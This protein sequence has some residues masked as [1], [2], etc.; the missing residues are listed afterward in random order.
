MDNL[1]QH[2][3]RNEVNESKVLDFCR[4][5]VFLL[6][7]LLSSRRSANQLLNHSD[8]NSKAFSNTVELLNLITQDKFPRLTSLEE[9]YFVLPARSDYKADS[10]SYILNMFSKEDSKVFNALKDRIAGMMVDFIQNSE[11][12]ESVCQILSQAGQ[13]AEKL[14]NYGLFRLEANN[15]TGPCI[16]ICEKVRHL[17]NEGHPSLTK[18]IAKLHFFIL[19]N[20]LTI[21]NFKHD[22]NKAKSVYD[23]Y[24]L[25]SESKLVN[26]I[27]SNNLNEIE[28]S[29]G[30]FENVYGSSSS[31]KISNL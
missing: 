11:S 22:L 17:V 23:K 9:F 29:Y 31:K 16:L 20:N 14:K 10:L 27:I 6:M 5:R 21:H 12:H 26:S 3:T 13:V 30:T 8:T 25:T 1:K 19:F 4:S 2:A 18:E 24:G 15:T 28:T 7:S